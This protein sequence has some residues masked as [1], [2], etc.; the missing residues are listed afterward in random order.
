MGFRQLRDI[1][2][3]LH[4]KILPYVPAVPVALSPNVVLLA[5]VHEKSGPLPARGTARH[6]LT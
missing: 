5:R 6:R 1:T 3:T 2:Y 4:P